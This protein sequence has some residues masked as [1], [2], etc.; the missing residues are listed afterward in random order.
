MVLIIVVSYLIVWKF[1]SNFKMLIDIATIISFL[2]APFCALLNHILVH[3]NSIPDEKKPP[4]WLTK[5]SIF[6]I[7]FLIFFL[8]IFV[9]YV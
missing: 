4:K 7:L 2:I 1:L 9:I 8:V 6:G 5:L 3:S